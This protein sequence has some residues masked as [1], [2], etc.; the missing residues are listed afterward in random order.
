[1]LKMFETPK[2]TRAIRPKTGVDT[3]RAMKLR[4]DIPELL[5]ARVQRRASQTIFVSSVR[6][7]TVIWMKRLTVNMVLSGED[8]NIWR[9]G[10][11]VMDALYM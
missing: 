11:E 5:I 4:I 1:M 9:K 10:S 2:A 3:E 8:H 6:S 7:I